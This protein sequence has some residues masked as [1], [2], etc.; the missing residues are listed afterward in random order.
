[1]KNLI[2]E[3]TVKSISLIE[4]LVAMGLEIEEEFLNSISLL[5]MN[6]VEEK[7]LHKIKTDYLKELQI[8][9]EKNIKTIAVLEN[10]Y[11]KIDEGKD[12]SDLKS[13]IEEL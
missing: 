13:K 8:E 2:E 1:M 9:I 3:K 5:D 4:E 12:I 10:L 11:K 6:N 7:E